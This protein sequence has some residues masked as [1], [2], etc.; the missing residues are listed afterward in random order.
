MRHQITVSESAL[1]QLTEGLAVN[2]ERIAVGPAGVSV[3]PDCVELLV[4]S[5]RWL[6]EGSNPAR[7]RTGNDS[8]SP[9]VF[10]VGVENPAHI[11]RSLRSVLPLCPENSLSA[12]VALGIGNASGHFAGVYHTADGIGPL[13]QLTLVGAHWT[14]LPL[15][16]FRPALMAQNPT[17]EFW[18]RSMGA[19]GEQNYQRLT[20]LHPCIVGCGRSGSLMAMALARLGIQQLTLIDPDLM[21]PHNLGEMDAV[22]PADLGKPKVEA[23]AQQVRAISSCHVV[24]IDDSIL[25]FSSLAKVKR[26]DLLVCCVDNSTARLASAFLATLYLKPLLDIGTGIFF[27]GRW[28]TMGA[29]IRLVV[30]NRCLLCFGSIANLEQARSEMGQALPS[31][32]SIDW[33][34]QRAGSLRS[35]NMLAVGFAL[36]LLEDYIS[37][38]V[39]ESR[40]VRLLFNDAGIPTL[41]QP[42]ANPNPR[43]YQ[44]IGGF[45]QPDMKEI[46]PYPV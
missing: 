2:P 39:Q 28:R 6:P 17:N 41:E 4:H 42:Q 29:D 9:Q 15:L 25:S 10:F 40:W 14:R 45:A 11:A 1:R 31:E 3:L 36:R 5:I 21:E 8:D 38:R 19:L 44:Q 46:R 22:T 20:A 37:G 30:P 35:L 27:Q 18:S 34:S 33:R 43:G 26:A 32:T 13:Y 16:P 24:P 12:I 23:I 7:S